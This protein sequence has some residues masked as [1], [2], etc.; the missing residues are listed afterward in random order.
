MIL[1]SRETEKEIVGSYLVG[2]VFNA[3]NL[4]KL[5]SV[6][7]LGILFLGIAYGESLEL[8]KLVKLVNGI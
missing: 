4:G 2:I 5:L 1:N 7:Q 8:L 3:F 6:R